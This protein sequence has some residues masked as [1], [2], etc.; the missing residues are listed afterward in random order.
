MRFKTYSLSQNPRT[1]AYMQTI[2][3]APGVA[4]WIA[5]ALAEKEFLDFE[6]PYR[7]S[8]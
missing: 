2:T 8:R 4:A 7:L 1:L 6:E 3:Q 5:D